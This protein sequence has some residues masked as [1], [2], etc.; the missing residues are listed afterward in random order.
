MI[1]RLGR[2]HSTVAGLL[3]ILLLYPLVAACGRAT[4][5]AANVG[6]GPSSVP[7]G[8][9]APPGSIAPPAELPSSFP[10]PAGTVFTAKEDANRGRVV[11][12]GFAPVSLEEGIAF[13]ARE[14]PRAGFGQRDSD[15][16]ENEAE[17]TFEGHGVIGRWRLRRVAGCSSG[18]TIH[19][20]VGPS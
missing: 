10:L 13:F 2:R 16:E 6:A 15:G 19:M 17:A 3:A 4:T 20:L 7:S 9:A 5:T 11:I 8:C 14:L 18:V 12:D 1:E